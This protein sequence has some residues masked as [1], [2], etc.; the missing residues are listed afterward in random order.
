MERTEYAEKSRRTALFLGS[1]GKKHASDLDAQ[2]I[3]ADKKAD[4]LQTYLKDWNQNTLGDFSAGELNKALGILDE[5][6]RKRGDVDV[7]NLTVSEAIDYY[8]DLNASLL[9]INLHLLKNQADYA[10]FTTLFAANDS[11]SPWEGIG[12][13]SRLS[14]NYDRTNPLPRRKAA[15]II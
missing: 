15:Y 12:L 6:E 11:D 7:L 2:R 4:S 1:D 3:V 13:L 10:Q 14:R 9:K 8:S 5:L